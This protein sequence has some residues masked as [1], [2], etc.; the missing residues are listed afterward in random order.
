MKLLDVGTIDK[1]VDAGEHAI[2]DL[3]TTQISGIKQV[4]EQVAR[5]APD[6]L[7]WKL[8]LH[9]LEKIHETTLIIRAPLAHRPEA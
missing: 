7:V 6:G 1:H 2:G 5:E 4:F 8:G 9:A 3:G